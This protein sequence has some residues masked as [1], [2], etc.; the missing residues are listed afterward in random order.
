MRIENDTS[1]AHAG[2]ATAIVTDSLTPI[3]NPASSAP[4]GLPSPPMM[5]TA[6]TTPSHVQICAGASVEISAMN[7]AR[8]AG[9]GGAHARQHEGMPAM[10]HAE[11][12]GDGRVLRRGAQRLAH[13]REAQP[14]PRRERQHGRRQAGE[15]LQHGNEH[16]ADAGWS[17]CVHGV[18]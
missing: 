1:G 14:C 13:V 12:A 2:A 16:R 18:S 8:H 6:N 5:T 4:T 7:V 3:R 17:C 15:Q 9:V 11:R 10:V